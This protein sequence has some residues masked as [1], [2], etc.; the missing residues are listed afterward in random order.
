MTQTFAKKMQIES[1]AIFIF[2]IAAIVFRFRIGDSGVGFMLTGLVI[3]E[4]M[5]VIFGNQISFVV[6]KLLKNH[7]SKGKYR[8]AG[9]I[10]KYS[11]YMQLIIAVLG[12]IC[13]GFGGSF[14]LEHLFKLP[15]ILFVA[16]VYALCFALRIISENIGGYLCGRGAYGAAGF[17]AII[18][19]V[20]IFSLGMLFSTALSGYGNK[21]SGLLKQDD[22]VSIYG[23]IGIGLSM[24]VSEIAVLIYMMIFK[25][26]A[27]K[28][29]SD[30]EDDYYQR[31]ENTGNVFLLIWG[32]RIF[33]ILNYLLMF[34]P[35]VFG[36]AFLFYKTEDSYLSSVNAGMLFSVVIAPT[37]LFV[38]FGYFMLYPLTAKTAFFMK[39]QQM[40]QARNCFETGFHICFVYGIFGASYLIAEGNILS[41][42]FVA[43][44]ST[45]ISNLLVY[46]AFAGILFLSAMFV[47]R[48]LLNVGIGIISYFI[49]IP[50]NVI[51][52]VFI[53]ILHSR[54][55]EMILC[56]VVAFLI[57]SAIL[58]LGYLILSLTKLDMSLNPIGNF[59]VPLLVGAVCGVLNLFLSKLISPHLGNLFTAIFTFVEML[60]VY[61]TLLLLSRNFHEHELEYLPGKKFISV[62]GQMFHV[63]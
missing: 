2:F 41:Y 23:C 56:F 38:A 42:L 21:V 49:Q 47:F 36:F 43:G 52:I 9:L 62:L 1:F 13:I 39:K 12:G 61:I 53:N 5:W 4:T 44:G 30:Y 40:R 55:K 6:G 15:H 46:S 60:F 57:Y 18:R 59:I 11:V 29:G 63:L 17:A 54:G 22:F 27:A 51:F 45:Q 14:L 34:L 28:N 20:G 8:S 26:A 19:A 7:Y 32:R 16:W 48:V 58:F 50:A 25:L 37:A 31:R 33:D 10:W 24:I 35:F 3:Y